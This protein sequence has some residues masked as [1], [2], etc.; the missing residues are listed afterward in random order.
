MKHLVKTVTSYKPFLAGLISLTASLGSQAVVTI[1]DHEAT[2]RSTGNVY[3]LTRSESWTI[4]ERSPEG[5]TSFTGSL[6]TT[7]SAGTNTASS[8]A[9]LDSSASMSM[10]NAA[11]SAGSSAEKNEDS[12][13]GSLRGSGQSRFE[14]AFELDTATFFN[15]TGSLSYLGER[16]D[17]GATATLRNNSYSH[18]STF[19]LSFGSSSSHEGF[20]QR[21][22]LSGILDAGTYYFSALATTNTSLY[23]TSSPEFSVAA[24]DL[25]LK[26]G[27]WESSSHSGHSSAVPV[28][29]AAWLFLSS[30]MGLF[31]AKRASASNK[32]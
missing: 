2:I 20:N 17:G 32:E 9:S 1:T 19:N 14:V 3:N 5:A 29:A 16:Y 7:R 31:T 10:I 30:I 8:S 22:N 21:I 15:L 12:S 18:D 25:S 4:E 23:S 26:L 6:N 13:Y 28:P 27:D 24:F 11:G